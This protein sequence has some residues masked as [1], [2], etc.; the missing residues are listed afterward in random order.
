MSYFT[1]E[2]TD[3]TFQYWHTRPYLSDEIREALSRST[4]MLVP[5]E[6]FR[7]KDIRVFPVG[8]EDFVDHLKRTLPSD[9]Q[10]ELAIT[11]DDYKEVALHSAVLIIGSIVVGGATL[12]GP[13]LTDVVSEY[14]KRRL[15]SDKERRETTVRWDLTMVDG[16]K[17]TK[18]TY[19]GPAIDFPEQMRNALSQSQSATLPSAS[20]VM[21]EN[22]SA[23]EE[24][25]DGENRED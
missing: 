20:I 18:I 2:E 8:T 11:D 17:A 7:G 19:D 12:L 10:V 4:V 22:K 13:V 16:T 23:E 24:K 21:I 3:K 1:I 14:I 5:Q 9:L 15:F 25:V 6:G